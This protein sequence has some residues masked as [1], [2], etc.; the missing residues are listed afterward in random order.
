M[1]V[2]RSCHIVREYAPAR[3]SASIAHAVPSVFLSG[4]SVYPGVNVIITNQANQRII[5][6]LGVGSS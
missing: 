4:F 1:V 3:G 6:S 5:K 2:D